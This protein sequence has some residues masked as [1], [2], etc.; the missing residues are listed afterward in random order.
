MRHYRDSIKRLQL[1]STK[2]TLR[3]IGDLNDRRYSAECS[4]VRWV[5]LMRLKR[6]C[7]LASYPGS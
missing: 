2:L 4:V 1:S 5:F 7:N 3:T 6:R